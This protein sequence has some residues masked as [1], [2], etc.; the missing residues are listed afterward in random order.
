MYPKYLFE[1]FWANLKSS[2]IQVKI[3]L[4]S[5]SVTFEKYRLL[6]ILTSGH[7][8]W[9]AKIQSQLRSWRV[10]RVVWSAKHFKSFPRRIQC[11][12]IWWY[13]ATLAKF[14]KTRVISRGLFR[15]SK[16]FSSHFGWFYA[17]GQI[18]FVVNGLM[19]KKQ[20]GHTASDGSILSPTCLHLN[21]CP[22]SW[23]RAQTFWK[24]LADSFQFF[25]ILSQRILVSS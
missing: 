22:N 17:I 6:F 10:T 19:M 13:F 14:E 1:T 21:T 4:A 11:D 3:T 9:I 2:S 8:D 18:F 16:F 12:Q 25:A 7:T 24:Q 23:Q 15:I 5:F 20:S